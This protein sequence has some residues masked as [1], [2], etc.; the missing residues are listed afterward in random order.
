MAYRAGTDQQRVEHRRDVKNGSSLLHYSERIAVRAM[1]GAEA[2]LLEL[3]GAA[4]SLE[5]KRSDPRQTITDLAILRHVAMTIGVDWN[6]LLR[7]IEA[8]SSP[9]MAQFLRGFGSRDPSSL[10]LELFMRRETNDANGPTI[11]LQSPVARRRLTPRIPPGCGQI[12]V[13]S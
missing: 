2:G 7:R 13:H 12:D 8:I 5:D 3:G 1:R 4:L 9:E 10:G 6:S 11:E